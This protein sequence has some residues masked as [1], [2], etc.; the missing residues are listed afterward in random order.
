M[1][2]IGKALG[3]CTEN[4]YITNDGGVGGCVAGWVVGRVGRANILSRMLRPFQLAPT[5]HNIST[6]RWGAGEKGEWSRGIG[7]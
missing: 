6:T 2:Q 7:G 1:G 5:P 4:I 3:G